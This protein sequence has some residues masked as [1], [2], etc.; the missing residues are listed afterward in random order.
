MREFDYPVLDS[1]A[2]GG[3]IKEERVRCS[4]TIQ[5]VCDALSVSPQ[6][7]GKWQRGESLPSIDNLVALCALFGVSVEG[8]L[9]GKDNMPSFSFRIRKRNMCLQGSVVYG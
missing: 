8:I 3:R 4:F 1:E 9:F 7:V 2:I 5:E 6:A